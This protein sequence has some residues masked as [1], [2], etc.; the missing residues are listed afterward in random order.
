MTQVMKL[1][2]Q[3]IVEKLRQQKAEWDLKESIMANQIEQERQNYKDYKDTA[4]RLQDQIEHE[5]KGLDRFLKGV[6]KEN[7][8]D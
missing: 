3:Q 6:G 5:K 7:V 1:L 8:L 4:K 2:H